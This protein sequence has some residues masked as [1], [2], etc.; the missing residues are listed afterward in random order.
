MYHYPCVTDGSVWIADQMWIFSTLS[1]KGSTMFFKRL[2]FLWSEGR[3]SNA[4][5]ISVERNCLLCIFIIFTNLM[6]SPSWNQ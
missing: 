1:P 5:Q 6:V 4:A 3:K 2:S